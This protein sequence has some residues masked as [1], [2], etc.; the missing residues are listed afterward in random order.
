MGYLT[1]WSSEGD[2]Q[3]S[4]QLPDRIASISIDENGIYACAGLHLVAVDSD[5]GA[6]SGSMLWKVALMRLPHLV[7]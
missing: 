3:W 2:R 4:A 1:K 7:G 5:S 6:I